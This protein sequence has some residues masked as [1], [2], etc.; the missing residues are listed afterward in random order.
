MTN[1]HGKKNRPAE[2]ITRRSL[3]AGIVGGATAAFVAERPLYASDKRTRV[4]RVESDDVWKSRNRDPQVIAAMVNR[5]MEALT[6]A[7][8]ATVAWK[9]VVRPDQ[10]V[11]LK[12]NLLGRP[13]IYSAHEITSAVTGGLVAAGLKGENILV[14]DRPEH[15]FKL[16]VYKLGRG[17]HGETVLGGGEYWLSYKDRRTAVNSSKCGRIPVDY[18][19]LT[20]TDITISLP[21]LK[22]HGICGVTGAL[23]NIAFGCYHTPPQTHDNCCD[24]FIAEAY[25]HFITVNAVPL[26]ILDATQGCFDGGPVPSHSGSLWKENAIYLGTDPVAIDVL[27]RAIIKDKRAAAGVDDV[28]RMTA[29]IETAASKGLGVADL[30]MIEVITLRV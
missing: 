11:G 4:V 30:N 17:E 28:T 14:W 13:L 19:P 2:E 6:G 8:S 7:S 26:I 1:S 22:H 12:I 16:T 18:I 23:K 27:C 29:H 9:S 21:V 3:L 15:H 10:R 24:P 5:G 20:R 25:Q